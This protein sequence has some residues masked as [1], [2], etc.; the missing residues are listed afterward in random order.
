MFLFYL[1]VLNTWM[2]FVSMCHSGN[3]VPVTRVG[4]SSFLSMS[5]RELVSR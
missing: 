4:W 2:E 5:E 1:C 3:T